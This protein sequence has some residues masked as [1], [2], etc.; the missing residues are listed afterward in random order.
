MPDMLFFAG[1]KKPE[2]SLLYDPLTVWN[3]A[4]CRHPEWC[5]DASRQQGRCF[6]TERARDNV[7]ESLAQIQLD[8]KM[9]PAEKKTL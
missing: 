3:W 9:A 8:S 1:G 7:R 2:I 4:W 5:G 6:R